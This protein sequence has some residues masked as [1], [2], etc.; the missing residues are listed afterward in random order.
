MVGDMSVYLLLQFLQLACCGCG[1]RLQVVTP[2][3]EAVLSCD[4]L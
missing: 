2:Y 1:L 4:G 3:P